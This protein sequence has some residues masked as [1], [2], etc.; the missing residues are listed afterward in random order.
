MRLKL[1]SHVPPSMLMGQINKIHNEGAWPI[2]VG[3]SHLYFQSVFFKNF[4]FPVG[5]EKIEHPILNASPP[6]LFQFL[7]RVDPELAKKFHPSD[8]LK[9]QRR[10]EVYLRTGR[11]P[12]EL[13]KEQKGDGFEHRWDTL[14]FWVWSERSVLKKRLYERVD[15]M[16]EMGLEEECRELYQLRKRS[17]KSVTSGIFKAIGCDFVGDS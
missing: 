6:E 1:Y 12:S 17:E 8:H 15:R 14:I 7:K 13:F 11:P 2:L 5:E 10:V 3:G 4:V 9:N 16:I